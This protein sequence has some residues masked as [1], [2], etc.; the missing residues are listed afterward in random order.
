MKRAEKCK[1]SRVTFATEPAEHDERVRRTFP[2]T[3]WSLIILV[4]VY[5]P[6][7][8]TYS[9][10]TR[11]YEADDEPAHV[12]YIEYIV[13][14][15]ALPRIAVANGLE[16]HQPPL[17]YA[18]EAGWQRLLG[19]PA[20][21]P[22][23]TGAKITNLDFDSLFYSH[24]YTPTEHANA[25]H[26]HE[27]RILSVVFGLGT[28]LLTY[29]AAKVIGMREWWA[30]A[31]G[32]FPALWPKALV[33]ASTVTNDALVTP[34]CALALVLFLLSE[35]AAMQGRL[36]H[37][38]LD[39]AAMG[40]A[41]GAAAITKFDSLPIA[42]VLLGLALVSSLTEMRRTNARAA[43]SLLFDVV[44]AV[45]AFLG[46]SGWWFVR[47]HHLYGQFLAT[48]ASEQYLKAFLLRPIPWS[49]NLL[50]SAYPKT[51]LYFSW[52]NQ[53]DLMLPSWLNHALAVP[54]V[55]C[56]LL[57]AWAV[58]RHRR[59]VSE[60]LGTVAAISLL[61]CVVAGLL[62]M[63]II[64]KDTSL[65]DVRDAFGA[66]AAIAILLTV[67]S[68]RILTRA[69]SR[70]EMVGVAFWPVVLFALDLY[71]LIRFLIPLGGL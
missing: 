67:G 15:D 41:L 5:I 71:V 9:F 43:V 21:T 30:L 60:R 70:L 31:C 68:V 53:P 38:R 34:L 52:W 6:M 27:L 65:A 48:N 64:L 49:S 8:L 24:D 57:G 59:W 13:G 69:S 32:L 47:N 55:L 4:L 46:V 1:A 44:L 39:L 54:A 61:G 56:L 62:A 36:G 19:I 17:Y 35:R 51:A 25:V 2:T 63:L 16:S 3:R 42:A 40:A 11:A 26:V 29:A 18:L 23:V 20:F 33:A 22:V 14:N 7:A 10:L 28:V 12:K 66:L 50:F 37:R 58:V 45:I